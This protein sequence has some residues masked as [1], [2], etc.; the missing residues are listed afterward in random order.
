LVTLIVLGQ[1]FEGRDIHQVKVSSGDL[2]NGELKPAIFIDA[3][4]HA[5]EWVSG[6]SATW[7]I[8]EIISNPEKYAEIL[9]QFDFFVVPLANPD[10]YEYSHGAGNRMWRKTRST[11]SGSACYGTDPNRNFAFQFG[12]LH[13]PNFMLINPHLLS[14]LI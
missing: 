5:R 2:P 10:G 6:A 4:F 9:S 13:L 3:H 12:M 8:N 14:F 7:I 11:N 1:S